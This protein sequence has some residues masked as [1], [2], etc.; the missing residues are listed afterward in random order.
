MRRRGPAG[1]C[2]PPSS[3]GGG[4]GQLVPAIRASAAAVEAYLVAGG[5]ASS[6]IGARGLGE[7]APIA[8]N[9]S[10]IGRAENRRVEMLVLNPGE[11]VRLAQV[12]TP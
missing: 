11:T 1:A 7:S 5:I 2:A 8:S 9:A 6:R 10:A 4:A 3:G 12:I